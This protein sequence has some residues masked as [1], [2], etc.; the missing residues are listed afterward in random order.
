MAETQNDNRDANI[1]GNDNPPITPEE[2]DQEINRLNRVLS[3][4]GTPA[5]HRNRIPARARPPRDDRDFILD[6]ILNRIRDLR[7]RVKQ[8]ETE[9]PERREFHARR[10]PSNL[11]FEVTY[12]R[13]SYDIRNQAERA[14]GYLRLKEARDMIPEF[15]GASS[16]L[17]EF[18]SAA[19]YAIKNINP[20]EEGTLLEAV[21]CTKLKG[22]AMTDFQ[23]R[24][25]RDF[26]QLKKELEVCYLSRKSTTH[27]QLEFNTLKQKPGESARAFGL[28]A[29]KLAM[30]LYN[31]MIEGRNHTIESKRTI[32]ETIQQQALQNFQLELRD[33]IK[34]L[35]RAHHFATLQE[36]IGGASAEEK[37]NGP[38]GNPPRPKN[39][40]AYSPQSRDNQSIIQ[41]QKCGKYG[42]HGRECRT[43][44]Y[45]NRFS[46][47]KPDRTPRVN[48]IDKVCNYCKKAGHMR[49]EC[50]LLNGRPNKER[51]NHDKSNNSRG[52]QSK[53]FHPKTNGPRKKDSNSAADSDEEDKEDTKQRR[54]AIEYQVSHMTNKP[55]KHAGLDLITLP[56][57]EAKREKINLLFDPGAAVSIIKVKHLKGETI[58]E[59]DEMALTGV[60]GHKI[61]TI[62][63]FTATIDLKDNQA[64]D[65]CR[66]R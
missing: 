6:E 60:T 52:G 8:L 27:L 11:P 53:N 49:E 1:N 62:G 51:T 50:W 44:R 30:E 20:M 61:H 55:R 18:L 47:P 22:R 23:T 33:E 64:H 26:A 39:N 10:E 56:M 46:L 59:E 43:S 14:I 58:I 65:I 42:H 28:R 36:A 7:D 54:P 57:R 19:S 35:V 48:A 41:C 34:L 37:I 4:R 24:E 17:Q 31:F 3:Q 40:Y 25:I 5:N 21:L 29:D 12:G 38:S 66:Q 32:L 15:D 9:N 16:K 2:I 63:K 45:A 13:T